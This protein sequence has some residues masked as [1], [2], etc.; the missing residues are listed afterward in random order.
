M[1]HRGTKWKG[2]T[3]EYNPNGNKQRQCST[4]KHVGYKLAVKV[5]CPDDI[6]WDIKFWI[7]ANY[8]NHEPRSKGDAFSTAISMR[9]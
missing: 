1:C 4:I 3:L 9:N 6:S 8:T 5:I 2:K 7:N